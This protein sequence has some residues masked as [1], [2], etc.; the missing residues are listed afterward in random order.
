MEK[1]D[2]RALGVAAGSAQRG[3]GLSTDGPGQRVYLGLAE[4]RFRPFG[5]ANGHDRSMHRQ[6]G[7]I[8]VLLLEAV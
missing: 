5:R 3:A 4:F 6:R 7:V 2:S 8:S 1:G